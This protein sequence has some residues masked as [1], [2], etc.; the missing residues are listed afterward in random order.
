MFFGDNVD[1]FVFINSSGRVQTN[2]LCLEFS[3]QVYEKMFVDQAAL[4]HLLLLVP[5]TKSKVAN[6]MCVFIS[7]GKK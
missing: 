2:L 3:K 5:V 1:Y 4:Q 6:I 7:D